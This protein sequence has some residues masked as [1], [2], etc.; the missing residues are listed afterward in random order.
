MARG[1]T[2]PV[3]QKPDG[4]ERYNP[5]KRSMRRKPNPMKLAWLVVTVANC[6]MLAELAGRD[7]NAA[8]A[9]S[10]WQEPAAALADQVAAILGP[11][12]SRLT[13][14]NASSIPTDEIPRIRLLLEED[15]KAHG[16]LTSGAESAN[17]IRV[18]LS[19]N[20]R[21]RLWVAE[22]IEGNQHQVAMVHVEPETVRQNQAATGLTLR[23]QIVLT[24][25]EPVLAAI[26][27]A[28]S[29]IAVE[30]EEIVVYVHAAEGWREQKRVAIGQRKPMPRDPRGVIVPSREGAGFEAFVAGMVCEGSYTP[31]PMAGEW[32]VRCREGDD[33]WQLSVPPALQSAATKQGENIEVTPLKA[34]YNSTR[35]YFTGVLAPSLGA[36]LPQFYTAAI[37]PRP[38]GSSSLAALLVNGIDGKVQLTETSAL[39]PVSGARDW[40][41]DFALLNSGC[42]TGTQVVA[43][44]SGEA[45]ADSLRAYDL[46]A[47]EAIPASAPLAMDGT[48]M[49]LWTAPD[50]KNVFAVVRKPGNQGAAI[51]YEVD[52]VT[53]SCN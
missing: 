36:D 24:T 23:K 50:S 22:V 20:L 13:I 46:P 14:R 52:R 35:D 21:E 42:G 9:P 47:Q 10:K 16:V 48:V 44:G 28:E 3:P 37:I 6:L 38:A 4:A 8:P 7:A 5:R 31:G 40:G 11:G 30:P 25:R 1:I 53:S 33:P 17:A 41:S 51:E 34:F 39:K 27:I 12:Q 49:A 18:T 45:L 15:L 19:E 26:E 32:T 43:S 2:S 29:L